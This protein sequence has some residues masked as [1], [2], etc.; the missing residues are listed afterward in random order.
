MEEKNNNE[1]KKENIDEKKGDKNDIAKNKAM[2]IIGYPFFFLFFIPL[3]DDETKNSPF[4]K[5]HANQQLA[6]LICCFGGIMVSSFLTVIWIGA[7][8]I[9]LIG[10]ATFAFVIMG[11][12]NAANGE[13]KKLPIIGELKLIK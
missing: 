12:I 7:I 5:F 4:A 6:I 10:I 11:M 2:A 3:L 1:E 13:M 8:L 9:P